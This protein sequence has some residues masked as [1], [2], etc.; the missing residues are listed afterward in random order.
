V[1]ENLVVELQGSGSSLTPTQTA[2]AA[3][4]FTINLIGLALG[5][6]A[7][8]AASDIFNR[9]LALGPAQGVRW[10]LLSSAMFAFP[11]AALFWRARRTIREDTVS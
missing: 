4:L 6:L 2:A 8:G 3:L 10:A 1:S 5:P 11:A 9:A 7:V